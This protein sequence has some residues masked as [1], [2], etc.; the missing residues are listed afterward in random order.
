MNIETTITREEVGIA[1]VKA[2]EAE[3]DGNTRVGT[4]GGV[5]GDTT[6]LEEDTA[7]EVGVTSEEE[8]VSEEEVASEDEFTSENANDVVLEDDE[9]PVS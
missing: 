8:V 1:K 7:T 9:A 2:V 5:S 6:T 3:Y 4:D